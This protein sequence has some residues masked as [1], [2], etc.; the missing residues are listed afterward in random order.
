M[1]DWSD[2][3]IPYLLLGLLAFWGPIIGYLWSLRTRGS[4][5]AEEAALLEEEMREA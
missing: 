5:L 1:I 3:N 2:K 4:H